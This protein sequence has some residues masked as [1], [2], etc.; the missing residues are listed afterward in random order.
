MTNKLD[1]KRFR[2]EILEILISHIRNKRNPVEATFP[3]RKSW[4]FVLHHSLRVEAC[5]EQLLGSTVEVTYSDRYLVSAACL[6]H[7]IGKL[8]VN[9]GHAKKSMEIVRMY[10]GSAKLYFMSEKVETDRLL[11]IIEGHSDKNQHDGDLI[12]AV[13]KDADTL[14]ELGFLSLMMAAEKANRGSHMFFHEILSSNE[15]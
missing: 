6:L 14:D 7:D 2:N 5:A 12:S 4:E 13:V 3:W 1:M 9:L 10:I 15:R 11:M 8:D